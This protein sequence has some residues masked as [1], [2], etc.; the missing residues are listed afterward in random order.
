M[1]PHFL[2]NC[3]PNAGFFRQAH[4]I[5]HNFFIFSFGFLIIMLRIYALFSLFTTYSCDIDEFLLF[6][7]ISFKC[8]NNPIIKQRETVLDNKHIHTCIRRR[9]L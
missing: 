4:V 9:L 7:Q 1:I 6:L 2:P 3:N 5:L 8:Y